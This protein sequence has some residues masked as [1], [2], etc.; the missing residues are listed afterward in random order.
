MQA[1]PKDQNIAGTFRSSYSL[2]KDN[3]QASAFSWVC[4]V[5]SSARGSARSL[6]SA[7]TSLEALTFSVV[8]PSPAPGIQRMPVYY[9]RLELVRTATSG[10][11]KNWSSSFLPRENLELGFPHLQCWT[12]LAWGKGCHSGN[13]LIFLLISMRLLLALSWPGMLWFPDLFLE[14]T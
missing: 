2:P 11:A 7:A 14:F 12:V 10:K 13:A 8:C 1:F 9:Q 3:L 5:P 4:Q 6:S